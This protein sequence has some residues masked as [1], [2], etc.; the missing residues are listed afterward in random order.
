MFLDNVKAFIFDMDGVLLDT[1]SLCKKCWRRA[2][3]DYGLCDVDTVF[4]KCVGQARQDTFN[5]LQA[6]FSLQKTD[7]NAEEFYL[8]AVDYFIEHENTYG[9]PLMK[10]AGEC[11]KRLSDAGFTLALA[12]STRT[13]TVRR[14]LERAGLLVYFK[15]LTCGDCVV[16]SKPDPE[17]YI[18]AVESIGLK[19]E[20]CCAVEDSPNGVRSAYGAGL[21]VLM[22]P[23]LIKPSEEIKNLCT[24]IINS[25]DELCP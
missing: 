7:F 13:E 3:D 18:K 6:F 15:T 24:K 25:L 21:K 12:S 10:G 16:H 11:L 9:L 5:T 19:A 23:D 22:V 2:A 14:Q 20:D 17:I 8:H 4:E 1:E